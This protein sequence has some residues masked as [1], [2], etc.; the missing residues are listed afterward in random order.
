MNPSEMTVFEAVRDLDEHCSV[1]DPIWIWDGSDWIETTPSSLTN[2]D[3]DPAKSIRILYYS[4]A[5]LLGPRVQGTLSD[6]VVDRHRPW[7]GDLLERAIQIALEAH[8]GQT[9]KNGGPY[10]LHPLAVMGAMDSP[11]DKI[12]AVLHDVVEDTDVQLDYLAAE[13]SSD[14]VEAVDALTKRKGSLTGRSCR[15]ETLEAYIARVR[16]NPIALRVKRADVAHNLSPSRIACLGS[17][18]AVRLAKKYA[19]TLTLLNQ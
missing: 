18:D 13:F 3:S 5:D 7:I 15:D 16:Q 2:D 6:M 17:K 10:I 1:E 9:D 14:V 12:V 11:V 8:A 4:M 19:Y